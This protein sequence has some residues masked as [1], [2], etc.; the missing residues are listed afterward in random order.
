MIDI[1]SSQIYFLANSITELEIDY[2]N[3]LTAAF[4]F[5]FVLA[6]RE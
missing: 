1:G 4:N 5:K 6:A 2:K 3:L